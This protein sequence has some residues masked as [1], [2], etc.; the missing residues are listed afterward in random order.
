MTAQ[1]Q[2]T[3]V[4]KILQS[5]KD[6]PP[7]PIVA[8]RVLVLTEREDTS[9]MDLQRVISTDLAL[10]TKILRVANSALFGQARSV[11]T[12]SQAVNL[13]GYNAIRSLVVAASVRSLFMAK[14]DAGLKERLLWEH[15]L[16]CGIAAR[17][18]AAR[19]GYPGEENAFL[20]GLMHD[21]GK[22]V[23]NARFPE[24]YGRLFEAVYNH[25]RRAHEIEEEHLGLSHP[26]LG[27]ILVKSWNFS[28]EL[29]DVVASHHDLSKAKVNLEAA[30]IVHFANL[31]CERLGIGG[32]PCEDLD[33]AAAESVPVLG[34]TQD[35]IDDLLVDVVAAFEQER[36]PFE[37]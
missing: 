6:L 30:A 26:V 16:G 15:A 11:A 9:P 7:M 2:G 32:R 22:V 18:L 17:L 37:G 10:A 23:M 14:G 13:L 21:I 8:Q 3:D 35:R 1:A 12:I 34:L 24:E 36:Q 19:L 20:G 4:I 27:A 29:E 33:L 31:L 5:T 25:R 28:A